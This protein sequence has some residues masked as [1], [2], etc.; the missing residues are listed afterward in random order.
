MIDG[1]VVL[2]Q[3]RH[4]QRAET[5]ANAGDVGERL[6]ASLGDEQ[7]PKAR[8]LRLDVGERRAGALAGAQRVRNSRYCR[9]S[10]GVCRV[11]F[12]KDALQAN[13]NRTTYKIE[14]QINFI[15][16][17]DDFFKKYLILQNRTNCN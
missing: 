14:N 4:H 15:D 7:S 5:L 8:Q 12:G 10:G 11:V 16:S 9:R 3:H 1:V 13:D 6:K 2:L 17:R